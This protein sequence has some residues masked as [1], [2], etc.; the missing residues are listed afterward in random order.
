MVTAYLIAPL[1][2]A[3][4][5]EP[6]ALTTISGQHSRGS[7]AFCLCIDYEGIS[8]RSQEKNANN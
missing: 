5:L 6:S 4:R 2:I 7:G 1:F 3:G 8:K